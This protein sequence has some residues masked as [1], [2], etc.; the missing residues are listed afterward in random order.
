MLPPLEGEDHVRILNRANPPL[1]S[2]SSSAR[3]E[4]VISLK[5]TKAPGLGIAQSLPLRADEVLR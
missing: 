4:L 1:C 5:T 2:S 3:S